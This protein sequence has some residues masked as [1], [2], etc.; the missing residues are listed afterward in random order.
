MKHARWVFLGCLACGSG[1]KAPS[2]VV[3]GN[4]SL[5]TLS[6]PTVTSANVL[7]PDDGAPPIVVI[8]DARGARSLAAAASWADL[9]A[10]KLSSGPKAAGD[11]AAWMY[12]KEAIALGKDP[13]YAVD[14]FIDF[15]P[16][17]DGRSL[18]DPPPPEEEDKPDDGSEESGGTGTAMALDEGKM[19]KHPTKKRDGQEITGQRGPRASATSDGMI[20]RRQGSIVGEVSNDKA[21]DVPAI[22]LAHPTSKAATVVKA[23]REL[24][25]MIGVRQ[26]GTIRPLHIQFHRLREGDWFDPSRWMEVRIDATGLVV[27]AVASKVSTVAWTD[28]SAKLAAALKEARD[29]RKL[30][31]RAPVDVL[32]SSD[33]D[34]QHLVDVLVALD[35]AGVKTIGLGVVPGADEMKLRGHTNPAVAVGT[36]NAQGDLDKAVIRA[37]VRDNLKFIRYCYEKELL[38]KPNLQGTVQVAFFIKPDGKVAQATASGVDVEVANCVAQAIKKIEFPKPKGGGGVQVNYPF[39]FSQ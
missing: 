14:G 33:V 29:R 24:E 5:A 37:K 27:E 20:P 9:S 28:M 30:D 23:V 25:A 22:V 19:G 10:G 12:V 34:A 18:D 17:P 32:V 4:A 7:A 13:K 8:V 38:A 21:R 2:P 16:I 1:A 3:T 6:V 39:T 15:K 35:A 11:D 36:P 26:G 31:P